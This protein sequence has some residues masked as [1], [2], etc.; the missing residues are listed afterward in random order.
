MGGIEA[1]GVDQIRGIGVDILAVDRMRR[2][3]ERENRFIYRVFTDE[4]I[5]YC[6]SQAWRAQH[7]AARFAAKEAFFKAFGTGWRDGMTWQ[8][9]WV[10][11]DSLGKPSLCLCGPAKERFDSLGFKTIHISLS[12]S[13]EF[14]VAF[15]ILTG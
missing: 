8:N 15:V 14:A 10:D 5:Q 12:H 11:R 6:E 4:E 1:S 3:L 9:V 13:R 7:F 2:I